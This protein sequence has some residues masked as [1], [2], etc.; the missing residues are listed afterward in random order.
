MQQ[1]EAA[2]I[3]ATVLVIVAIGFDFLAPLLFNS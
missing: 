3:V 2:N 1:D